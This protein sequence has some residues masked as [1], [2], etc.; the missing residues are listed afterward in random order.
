[1]LRAR[2]LSRYADTLRWSWVAAMSCW[3]SALS[4]R[5]LLPASAM[6]V[7]KVAGGVNRRIVDG[8]TL[9]GPVPAAMSDISR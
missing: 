7:S 6:N 2:S 4:A 1:M 3:A 9:Y 8:W 5:P